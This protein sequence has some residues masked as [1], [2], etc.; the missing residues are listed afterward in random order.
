MQKR[1]GWSGREDGY[2]VVECE[3]LPPILQVVFLFV[4]TKERPNGSKIIPFLFPDFKEK[5][6]NSD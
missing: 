4:S 2:S 3:T 1:C 6:R 5:N